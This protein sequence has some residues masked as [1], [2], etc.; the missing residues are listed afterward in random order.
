M[1]VLKYKSGS[2]WVT[3]ANNPYPVGAI[4][5]SDRAVSPATLFGGTWALLNNSKYLRFGGSFT[6]G[7]SSSSSHSHASGSLL[8]QISMCEGGNSTSWWRAVPGPGGSFLWYYTNSTT[9]GGQKNGTY[10]MGTPITG[11]TASSNIDITPEYQN[12]YAYRRTA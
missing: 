3:L 1:A 12:V 2:A 6:T 9:F 7:G 5:I 10:G 11:S 8:A 4:Y